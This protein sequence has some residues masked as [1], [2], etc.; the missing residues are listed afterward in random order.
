MKILPK[1]HAKKLK[2][3]FFVRQ[4][5]FFLFLSIMLLFGMITGLI[6]FSLHKIGISFTT[7]T[8]PA[9]FLWFIC[10]LCFILSYASS[11]YLMNAVFSPME[12]LS[13]ASE[14]IAAGKYDT[15][16]SY[17][18]HIA[19]VA[20]VF[21]KFNIMAQ[22][23]NSVELMRNDFIANV[24]HEFKTPLSSITGYV[25]LLQDS[26]LSEEERQDYIKRAFFNIE[27]LN[28]LTSNILQLSKLE[29]QTNLLQSENYRLDEQIREAIVLLEPKWNP[30]Q[31]LLDIDLQ[32]VNYTGPQTLLFQV[33]T[34]LIS[35]AI[36]FS[37]P[38]GKIS[39]KLSQTADEVNV[40]LSDNGIGMSEETMSHIFEKFYQGDSSRKEQG[41][42]LG[43]ALC[44]EILDR[45]NGNIYVSS[46][47]GNGATFMVSLPN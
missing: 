18:G 30:K 36:K 41:N 3:Y 15:R 43:L 37:N 20:N 9:L 24:S 11:F 44:K 26:D 27:K 5:F 33:W 10:V 29:N 38:G 31:L 40:L 4:R 17:D 14:Q 2:K 7:L 21:D 23:I 46:S 6:V 12:E 19:E 47:P 45:C 16:L 39:I 22:E 8:N 35:N 25:T 34:N 1:E 28:D 42:G 13:T 32:E